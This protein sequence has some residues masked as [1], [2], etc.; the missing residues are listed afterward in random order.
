[1]SGG[2]LRDKWGLLR[3]RQLRKLFFARTISSLGDMITPVAL[4]FAVLHFAGSAAVIPWLKARWLEA[5]Q[6]RWAPSWLQELCPAW[7]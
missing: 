5:R 3:S 7:C 2:R 1:M 6:R 4:A